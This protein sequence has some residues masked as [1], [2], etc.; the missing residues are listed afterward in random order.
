MSLS[1]EYQPLYQQAQALQ[2]QVYDALDNHNHPQAVVLR[3]EMQ[4]LVDDVQVQKNPRDIENRLRTIQHVMHEARSN[5]NNG[6]MNFEHA[7][8]FHQ[9]FEQM[10][11]SMRHFSDY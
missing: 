2:H 5:Q 10:G 7:D 4:R 3:N 11:R 8:H 1:R 9:T 6:F